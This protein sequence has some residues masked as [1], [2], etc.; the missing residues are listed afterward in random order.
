MRV[1]VGEKIGPQR[2][3]VESDDDDAAGHRQFMFAK[4]PPHQL[5]LRSHK[6]ALIGWRYTRCRRSF[7]D[8]HGVERQARLSHQLSSSR[9][10][11]SIHTRMM[12]EINVP[13][14]VMTPSIKTIVPARNISWA[15]RALSS[16]GPTVGRP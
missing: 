7:G 5:P 2:R 3:Q 14:T 6:N 12:S 4:A 13:T 15:M 8:R 10:R 16:S 1:G 9:M 11:G